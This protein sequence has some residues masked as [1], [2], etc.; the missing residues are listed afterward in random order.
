MKDASLLFKSFK[1]INKTIIIGDNLY[2]NNNLKECTTE[3][4]VSGYNNY[5]L[6]VES[7]EHRDVIDRILEQDL[8]INLYINSDLDFDTD[9]AVRVNDIDEAIS[10]INYNSSLYSSAIFTSDN[11]HASKFMKEVNSK[12]VMVNASPTLEQALDIKEEDLLRE[13]NIVVPNNIKLDG[14]RIEV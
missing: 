6:Y 9:D 7:L 5:D 3:V 11:E 4:Q 14:K 13:K 12:N 8:N 1:T 10:Y 2:I